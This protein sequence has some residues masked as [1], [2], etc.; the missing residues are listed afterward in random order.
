MANVLNPTVLSWQHSNKNTDGSAFTS[1]QYAGTDV[2]VD[3]GAA[4]ALTVPYAA[5][6]HYQIPVTAIGALGTGTHTFAVDVKH[7]N[8]NKSAFS[9]PFAFDVDTRVP[10][11]PFG[12]S[13]S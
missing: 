11:V 9:A 12:L 7:V 10:E 5:D 1:A 6:G 3:G 8:G 13:A 2:S 4:V